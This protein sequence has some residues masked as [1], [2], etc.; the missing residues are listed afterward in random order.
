[1][2]FRVEPYAVLDTIE[3]VI[4]EYEQFKKRV[5]LLRYGVDG[6]VVKVDAV[7]QQRRLGSTARSPRWAVAFKYPAQQASTV[8]EDIWFSVGRTGAVTPIARV[9]PVFCAGVTISNVSLHNF[10]EVERLG[11]RAG[12]G[13]L[14]ERA[15]EVIPKLVKVVKP[16]KSGR[17]VQPPKKCPVCGGRVAKEPQFVAYYCENPSCPARIRGS[18][19]HFCSRAAMDIQGLGDQVADALIERGSVKTLSDLYRLGKEALLAVPLFAEKRA[20]NLLAEIEDSKGRP[21]AKLLYGL[22]IRHVG[23]KMAEILA[24]HFSMEEL[25]AAPVEELQRVPEVGPVVAQ[26]VSDFFRSSEIRALIE[27][28]RAAGL[29]LRKTPRAAVAEYSPLAGKTFVFTGELSRLTREEASEKV[30]SLGAKTSSSVSAKTSFVVAGEAAG[31][32]LAKARQL[33]VTVLDE[34]Q[35]IEL[36]PK[37]VR[38]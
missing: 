30:K 3:D 29:D 25:A 2:G 7:A 12:D 4:K 20:Q 33:G 1:M 35:F 18:L 10:D 32:K 23:E 24:E 26:T 13:V 5:P 27:E 15:G 34:D 8:V 22:G 9:K 19:L 36:L 38:P 31:S 14:I 6:L 16:A 21:F 28:L 17:A 37:E 11:V